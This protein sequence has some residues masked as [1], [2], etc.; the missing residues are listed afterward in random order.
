MHTV[1]SLLDSQNKTLWASYV[2]CM[3]VCTTVVL[4][5]FVLGK[6][7]HQMGQGDRSLKEVLFSYPDEQTW[8]ALGH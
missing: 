3:Y 1:Q 7:Q 5:E 4:C 6:S 2:A 8:L